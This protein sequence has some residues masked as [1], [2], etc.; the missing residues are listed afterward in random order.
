MHQRDED[1]PIPGPGPT[2]ALRS[3]ALHLVALRILAPDPGPDPGLTPF[4]PADPVLAPMAG[5]TFVPLTPDVTDAVT[6]ARGPGPALGQG[7]TAI[8]ALAHHALLSPI[9]EEAGMEQKL[10]DPTGLGRAPAPLVATGA[11]A[12]VEGSP[13]LGNYWHTR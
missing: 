4:L 1:G 5:P 13:L 3:A 11:T 2:A 7:L 12:P 6:D 9:G 8:G 10:P